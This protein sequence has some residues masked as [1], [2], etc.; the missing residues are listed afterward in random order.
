M[1]ELAKISKVYFEIENLSRKRAAAADSEF[2]GEVIHCFPLKNLMS[3]NK[4][5]YLH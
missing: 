1:E 2:S 3:L 4:I 5:S